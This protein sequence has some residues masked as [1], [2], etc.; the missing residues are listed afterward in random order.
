MLRCQGGNSTYV[1]NLDDF[2]DFETPIEETEV[3]PAAAAVA[4]DVDGTVVE[5]GEDAPSAGAAAVGDA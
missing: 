4:V 1:F 2:P 3:V 5:K